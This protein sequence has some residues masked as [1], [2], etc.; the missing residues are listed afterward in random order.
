MNAGV[1]RRAPELQDRIRKTG[2]FLAL[3]S[4]TLFSMSVGFVVFKWWTR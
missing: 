3:V 1:A 2:L 4:F